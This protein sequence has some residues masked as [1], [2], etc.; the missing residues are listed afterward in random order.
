LVSGF[1]ILCVPSVPPADPEF[2]DA[3]GE[4]SAHRRDCLLSLVI[5]LRK[6]IIAALKDDSQD[7]V[8]A[9]IVGIQ[10]VKHSIVIS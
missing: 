10:M 9:Y 1:S 5:E 8:D 7:S 6:R 3:D 4:I 2:A